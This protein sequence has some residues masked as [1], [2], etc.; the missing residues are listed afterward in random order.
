M[1]SISF[2]E[3]LLI[4]AACL[5][6]IGPKRLPETARFVGHLYSRVTRQVSSIR[7][8]IRREMDMEDMRKTMRETEQAVRDAGSAAKE[9]VAE[10]AAAI[11][12]AASE[13]TGDKPAAGVQQEESGKPAAAEEK[14]SDA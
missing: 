5:I 9:V 12:A 13:A 14:G 11:G 1:F 2:G 6:V 7:T 4:G 10:P 8:D 3:M